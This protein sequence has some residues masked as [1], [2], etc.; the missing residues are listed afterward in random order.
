MT[1]FCAQ[2]LKKFE[3]TNAGQEFCVPKCREAYLKELK[4]E[5]SYKR[6]AYREN[7]PTSGLPQGLG[8]PY[9]SDS[10]DGRYGNR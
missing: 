7:T 5:R 4:T 2:C 3:Q 6:R 10:P 9:L 8:R 1:S